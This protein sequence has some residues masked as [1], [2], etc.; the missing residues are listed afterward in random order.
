MGIE[1]IPSSDMPSDRSAIDA[2]GVTSTVARFEAPAGPPG[3][4]HHHGDHH[5]IAYLISGKV[6]I[7]SGPDGSVITD[8]SPGDLVHIEPGTVHR[9]S[10]EGHVEIV[11][12]TVG[13]G[14]GRVD[15]AGPDAKG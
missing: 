11:G 6:R 12:F 7:E 3:A 1:H 15:V 13:S 2:D 10:Y 5:V 4:W 9:E 14:P 8:P